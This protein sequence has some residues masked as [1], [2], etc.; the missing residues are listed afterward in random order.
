VA[1][2]FLIGASLS[3]ISLAGLGTPVLAQEGEPVPNDPVEDTAPGGI[4]DI[5]VTAQRVE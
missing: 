4:T 5:V 2:K 3:A 1:L